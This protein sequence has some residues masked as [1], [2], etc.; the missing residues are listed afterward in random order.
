MK[1]FFIKS[2][3]FSL[4]VVGLAGLAGGCFG[5]VWALQRGT[6]EAKYIAAPHVYFSVKT[7]TAIDAQGN[8]TGN[9]VVYRVDGMKGRP[10][11]IVD[12]PTGFTGTQ[13]YP[14]TIQYDVYSASRTFHVTRDNTGSAVWNTSENWTSTTFGN[15]KGQVLLHTQWVHP[16]GTY[17]AESEMFC[18]DTPAEGP[19]ATDFRLTVTDLTTGRQATY[20]PATFGV[21]EYPG[22]IGVL[23]ELTATTAVVQISETQ[24]PGVS[25]V[26]VF[27]FST[28]QV[29]RTLFRGTAASQAYLPI[30][31]I[32]LSDDGK[33]LY[34]AKW[35]GDQETDKGVDAMSVATGVITSIVKTNELAEYAWPAGAKYL[36]YKPNDATLVTYDPATGR[37]TSISWAGTIA[38]YLQPLPDRFT[39]TSVTST[40]GVASGK[41]VI[42]DAVT[43]RQRVIFDQR[44]EEN[45]YGSNASGGN[46]TRNAVVGD[47]V[48]RFLGMEQ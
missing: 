44:H 24:E 32:R 40:T 45:A 6:D 30:S 22:I 37:E 33:S 42:T 11:K 38:E 15:T 2:G 16:K 46:S 36:Y 26:G 31:F 5:Y 17:A 23:T 9:E 1:S 8:S 7:I 28:G 13:W 19:C 25:F 18:T 48:Y 12:L 41:L 14:S 27:D 29:V 34:F 47:K 35:F 4:G 21:K 3:L 20:T 10:V 39:A 43:G